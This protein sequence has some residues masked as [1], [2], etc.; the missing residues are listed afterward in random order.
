MSEPA[1]EIVR[2]IEDVSNLKH[3]SLGV[4]AY[5]AYFKKLEKF[6]VADL[7]KANMEKGSE[8]FSWY[9]ESAR[10]ALLQ[11]Y[12]DAVKTP[13]KELSGKEVSDNLGL[14]SVETIVWKRMLKRIWSVCYQEMSFREESLKF[15]G[16]E[17]EKNWEEL[18]A[19]TEMYYEF[20]KGTFS[21]IYRDKNPL[22]TSLKFDNTTRNLTAQH[23]MYLG[24]LC[25]F[26]DRQLRDKKKA[27]DKKQSQE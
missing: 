2:I 7:S 20:L 10:K 3:Q 15:V 11:M 14:F 26:K 27:P 12:S 4:E 6:L 9:F 5:M 18:L 16:K 24:D 1:Q 17:S 23:L 25:K 22:S 19:T 8:Q 13:G 21:D